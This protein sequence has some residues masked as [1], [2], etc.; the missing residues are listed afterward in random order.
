MKTKIAFLLTLYLHTPGIIHANVWLYQV[1]A[2]S[3]LKLRA[4]PSLSAQ[5]LETIPFGTVLFCTQES[6]ERITVEETTAPW[7]MTRHDGK[8]GW[9]F[10]GF[11]KQP[12]QWPAFNLN[13]RML[14][15]YWGNGDGFSFTESGVREEQPSGGDG[16]WEADG[17]DITIMIDCEQHYQDSSMSKN[18]TWHDQRTYTITVLY[19][20]NDLL[21]YRHNGYIHA[22]ERYR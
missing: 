5:T 6:T 2:K 20:D 21:V 15:G 10:A 13:P 11:L 3:G 7:R 19:L 14:H 18:P 22:L 1:S 12:V 17:N 16:T 4:E 9:V 8:R